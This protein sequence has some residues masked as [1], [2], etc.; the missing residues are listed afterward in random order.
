MSEIRFVTVKKGGGDVDPYK[1]V[2]CYGGGGSSWKLLISKN[3]KSV[4]GWV[5]HI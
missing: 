4:I 3:E 1:C 2:I 5:K